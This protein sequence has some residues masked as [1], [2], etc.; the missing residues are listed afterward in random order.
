MTLHRRTF[1]S[2]FHLTDPKREEKA[3]QLALNVLLNWTNWKP[4]HE[5]DTNALIM[6]MMEWIRDQVY[7]AT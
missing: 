7:N 3:F 2:I 5:T 4:G 6:L 1:P